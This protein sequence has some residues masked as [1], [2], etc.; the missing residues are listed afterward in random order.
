M[1]NLIKHK[2]DIDKL[3]KLVDNI[4]HYQLNNTFIDYAFEIL[5]PRSEDRVRLTKYVIDEKTMHPAYFNPNYNSILISYNK[6]NN[7]VEENSL[8]FKEKNENISVDDFKAYLTI[9]L[10]SHELEHAYQYLSSKN[11][12]DNNTIMTEVYKNLYNLFK[13]EDVFFINPI[14]RYRRLTSLVLYKI[15]ENKYLLER[16]A[17]LEAFD[18]LCTI[19][20]LED[21]KKI[22][23]CFNK[24]N[25]IIKKTG[26]ND[27]YN[28]S[29]EETYKKI[30]MSDVYKKINISNEFSFEE[31]VRFGLP[32]NEREKKLILK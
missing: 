15:N 4:R 2:T 9:F 31:K 23:D 27:I 6:I 20:D 12:C 11:L 30:L 24:M 19:S 17:N 14:K 18:L 29:I 26:Y 10:I 21:N 5:T 22:K 1:S 3:T 16:N 25:L 28:G 32:I 8:K 7:W 13:P